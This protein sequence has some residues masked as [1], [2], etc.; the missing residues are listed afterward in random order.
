MQQS[1]GD[2]QFCRSPL[3]VLLIRLITLLTKE[4]R[5]QYPRH[6]LR[7]PLRRLFARLQ[8]RGI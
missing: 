1:M 4:L 6:A 3:L 2:R 7:H 5:L 8:N